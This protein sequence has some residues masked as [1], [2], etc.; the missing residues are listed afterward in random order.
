MKYEL[1]NIDS[2]NV[3]ICRID[4]D[5][6][7]ISSL[8]EV[9][10]KNNVY[11]GFFTGIGAVKDV[12]LS[13]YD[14]NSRSYIDKRFEGDYEIVS[15]MGNISY[16]YASDEIVVHSH[17]A[18]SDSNCVVYGGHLKSAVVSVTCEIFIVC[19]VDKLERVFN[20]EIGL[21]LLKP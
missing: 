14:L 21:Y 10:K 2:R 11:G 6:E 16:V 9:I 4:K 15:L 17:M 1:T 7:I 3:I 18:I 8:K 5:E 13:Y 19:V 12:V 20:Q